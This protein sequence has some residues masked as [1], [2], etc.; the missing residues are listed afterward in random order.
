MTLEISNS[1]FR[2]LL[3]DTLL[4]VALLTDGARIHQVHDWR[5]RCVALVE[6]LRQ[7]MLDAG[8]DDGLI[9]EIG[10]AQCVLLDEI[11]LRALPPDQRDAWVRETL[12]YRFHTIRDGLSRV[13]AQ[14]RDLLNS[15][16]VDLRLFDMYSTFYAFDLLTDRMGA[17]WS[18]GYRAPSVEP[19]EDGTAGVDATHAP[20]APL[21]SRRAAWLRATASDRT[22]RALTGLLAMAVLAT[23]WLWVDARI[24]RAVQQLQASQQAVPA[25]V[26]GAWE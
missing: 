16:V 18:H 19:R 15:R 17:K 3:Q 1:P 23:I 4:H 8:Y 5:A 21:A 10:L 14:A 2:L 9:V 24:E 6:Q 7:A 20:L 25:N 22:A 13:R 11:T 26:Q 12:Q